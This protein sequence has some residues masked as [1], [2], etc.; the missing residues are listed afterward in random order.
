VRAAQ[1]MATEAHAGQVDKAG[2]PYIEH[3]QRVVG[4]LVNPTPV[5]IVVAWLHDVVED[6]GTTLEDV[7]TAFGAEVAAAVDALTH[8][9]GEAG[10]VYYSRV[11]ANASARVVKDADLADN[12]D[13][14]RLKLL[15][16]EVRAE[17][18]SKYAHARSELGLE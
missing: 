17:L 15:D 3:P 12:T 14:E 8:R 1:A 5:Q 16:P 10:D 13:P 4:H 11:K 2:C 7:E 6:T 18:E 9:P